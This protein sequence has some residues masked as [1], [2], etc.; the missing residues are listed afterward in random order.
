MPVFTRKQFRRDL[1]HLFTHD[2]PVIRQTTLG[3]QP[4]GGPAQ[5]MSVY[6]ADTNLS[7]Q[8]MFQNAWIAVEASTA[9][10]DMAGTLYQYTI[11]SFNTGSGA[12]I[13]GMSSIDNIGNAAI[14]EIHTR[15]SPS[16]KDAVVDDTILRT[17][18]RQEVPLPT[19]DGALFYTID[20]AASPYLIDRIMDVHISAD[21]S[22]SLNT[23]IRHITDW[24]VVQTG[25]GN[26]LR[27]VYA[28]QG[29]Q[30]LLVDAILVPTLSGGELATINLPSER[31]ILVGAAARCYDLLIQ[32]APA[33]Q[34]QM[35]MQR[36]QEMAQEFSRLCAR[37][38]PSYDAPVRLHDVVRG[39]V[40]R[41]WSEPY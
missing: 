23:D 32:D 6:A 39:A 20:G 29:S 25:S 40:G 3:T 14:F 15:I 7:G 19:V 41:P 26:L 38:Q 31:W 5:V 33:T 12:F 16:D 30:Q 28:V 37:Y 9:N 36:R 8:N 1:A 10:T 2:M 24:Q 18:I 4:N 22:D 11:G 34:V 13:S 35:L 17:R 21:P 27:L